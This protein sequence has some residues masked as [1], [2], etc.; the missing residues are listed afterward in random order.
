MKRRA[1]LAWGSFWPTL[2]VWL[3][4][5]SI[6]VITEATLPKPAQVSE[7]TPNLGI[8]EFLDRPAVTLTILVVVAEFLMIK[9]LLM[10]RNYERLPSRAD[11]I[12]RN[13][14]GHLIAVYTKRLD[15]P[16]DYLALSL[17]AAN[18]AFACL[19]ILSIVLFLNQDWVLSYP[20]EIQTI[21]NAARIGLVVVL[22]WG[23]YQLLSVP[24][25][26]GEPEVSRVGVVVTIALAAQAIAVYVVTHDDGRAE[27]AAR[28]WLGIN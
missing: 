15:G 5:L 11:V 6:L 12:T 19:Y 22:V 1:I 7:G 27:S 2:I 16:R 26:E 20:R 9:A 21:Q 28:K 4:L 10:A 18:V 17:I 13:E 25:A 14:H 24:D 23:G 3:P 8:L